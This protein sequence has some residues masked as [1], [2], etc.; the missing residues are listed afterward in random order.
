MAATYGYVGAKSYFTGSLEVYDRK[1][2]TWGDRDWMACQTDYLRRA[3]PD[4]SMGP[5]GSGDFIDPKTGQPKCYRITG[6]GNNGVTINTLGSGTIAGVGAPGTVT[7]TFNRWRPNPSVTTGLPGYEGVGGGANN[8]NVRDTF[9]P[10]MH[11]PEPDF[12]GYRRF[13]GFL[14][15]GFDTGILGNSEAYYE[16]LDHAARLVADRL[17]PTDAGLHARQPA[18]SRQPARLHAEPPGRARRR[19]RR[20]RSSTGRSSP[21]GNY[22]SEQT[23]DYYKVLAGLKGNLP[24]A[25]WKYDGVVSFAKSSADYGFETFLTDR[26]TQQS[27]RRAERGR[28]VLLPQYR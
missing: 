6:T 1:E 7:S 16:A 21:T 27:Q 24:C 22:Q 4:G 8:L 18:D 9:E 15:G 14:Q 17:P 12:T 20:A 13:S 5:W 19:S 25:D 3:N 23:V 2:L 10:R 26:V 28:F 11:E